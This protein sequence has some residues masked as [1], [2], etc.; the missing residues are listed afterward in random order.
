M[1]SALNAEKGGANRIELCTSLE[2]G[3]LTPTRSLIKQV[4]DALNIPVYVLIR[5]R[6]GSFVYSPVELEAMQSDISFCYDVG[7]EGVVFGVLHREG[8]IDETATLLLM[9]T[10]KFMDVTFHRAFDLIHDHLEGLNILKELG[11]QRILTSG[12]DGNAIQGFEMLCELVDEAEDEVII[13][14]GGGI[15]P[16][17]INQL[18]S[19]G[20][21]EYHSAAIGP[22]DSE[23]N[24]SIIRALVEA[25]T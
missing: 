24:I 13:M 16:K 17:N 4:K 11:V 7:C 20:A 10:A 22:D 2:V 19:T 25:I 9:E 23:S 12:C 21:N 18:L 3:G 6:K 8:G 1:Q 5:P 14:P 15:R